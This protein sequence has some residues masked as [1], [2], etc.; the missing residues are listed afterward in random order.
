M[1]WISTSVCDLKC[2]HCY[3]H[4]GRRSAGELDTAQATQLILD[5]LVLLDRPT[6]VLA[7]GEPLLRKDFPDFVEAMAKHRIP[8]ALHSHGGR[9]LRHVDVFRRFRP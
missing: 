2:P 7:G 8:W 3:S 4:A 5:E 1:Q 6:L 9:V